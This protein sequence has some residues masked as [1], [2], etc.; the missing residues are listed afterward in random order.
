AV[1]FAIGQGD[2]AVT[3]L[4]LARV[5]AAVANGGTL[6]VPQ[7]AA[8][9]Q[10]Q[11]GSQRTQVSAV[12]AGTVPLTPET[13]SFLTTALQGVITSGTASGVFAGWPQADY[14]LAG[15]TGSAEVF[16]KQATSWFASL[17][18]VGNPR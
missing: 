11:D 17:G 5:Y 10:N 16:G 3:P 1:N 12:A 7:V 13:R 8:A 14:P 9:T 6:W 2:V 15:K 18:P 4:Q